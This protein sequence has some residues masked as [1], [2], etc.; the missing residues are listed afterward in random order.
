MG[1]NDPVGKTGMHTVGVSMPKLQI[2]RLSRPKLRLRLAPKLVLGAGLLVLLTTAGVM[3]AAYQ[4]LN[5]GFAGRARADIEVNLRTLAVAFSESYHDAKIVY[6]GDRVARVEIPEMPTFKDH[7]IVDRMVTYVG[8]NATIFVLDPASNQFVRRTTNVKK[9]N[10]DR[11]VGTQLAADHP[12]QAVLRRGEAYKGPAVLFGTNYYTAYQP[13]FDAKRNT[14]GILYVGLPTAQ[15]DAMLSE[16]MINMMWAA[17][18]GAIV[19]MLLTIF[20]VHRGIRPLRSVTQTADRARRR[21][22]RRR[23]RPH[24]SC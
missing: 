22:P 16:T 17:A 23:G 12:G 4:S 8:G 2:M 3:F 7:A 1:G 13:V 14:V 9:E 21:Q 10:G 11:A 19:V 24:R 18:L 6:D 15:Y 5:A 20:M